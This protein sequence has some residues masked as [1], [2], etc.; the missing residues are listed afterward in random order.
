MCT[1]VYARPMQNVYFDTLVTGI[2]DG[3]LNKHIEANPV[4]PSDLKYSAGFKGNG[5]AFRLAPPQIK[6]AV[7]ELPSTA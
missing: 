2:M 6:E 1:C 4:D 5:L 7:R 3:D